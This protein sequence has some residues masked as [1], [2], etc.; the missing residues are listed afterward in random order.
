MVK[1]AV[2]RS[3]DLEPID[4]LEE[5]VKL[6]VD[7]ITS[8]RTEQ[9][10]AADENARLTREIDELRARLADAEGMTTELTVLRDERD[11]I[12]TRVAEMLQQLETI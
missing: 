5:K 10:Q 1:Q 4:R 11:I 2:A 6:L 12:R 7:M 8:L 3:V 9:T